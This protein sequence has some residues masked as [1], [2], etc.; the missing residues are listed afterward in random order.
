MNRL[1]VFVLFKSL[2]LFNRVNGESILNESPQ[3]IHLT[4][5]SSENGASSG[6]NVLWWTKVPVTSALVYYGLID[7][8][9]DDLPLKYINCQHDSVAKGV[10]SPDLAGLD[11]YVYKV[12]INNLL[13]NRRYCY[14]IQSGRSTSNIH[15]FRTAALSIDIGIR[16]DFNFHTNFLIYPESSIN[17]NNTVLLTNSITREMEYKQINSFIHLTS[18]QFN[19]KTNFFDTFSTILPNIQLMPLINSQQKDDLF[20]KMFPDLNNKPEI[21][22]F[23]SHNVNGVHFLTYSLNKLGELQLIEMNTNSSVRYSKFKDE[24]IKLEN[25]LV[26]ANRNRHL[27]PWIIVFRKGQSTNHSD[28]IIEK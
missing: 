8:K 20:K 11:K 12:P 4:Y 15:S 24:M 10:I 3:G 13:P 25:D 19:Y 28:F 9:N 5:K 27:V 18:D 26:D 16:E 7:L 1:I 21:E 22:S 17:N 2:L 6:L 23:Y 14:E